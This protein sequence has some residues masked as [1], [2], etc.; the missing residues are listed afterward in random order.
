MTKP[1]ATGCIKTDD[2]VSWQTFNF[3]LESV[4]L[5]DKIGHLYVVDIE[6]NFEKF[7]ARQKVYNEICPPIIEKKKVIDIFERS[8]YQLTKHYELINNKVKSYTPTKKAHA[9]LFSKRCF[10]MYIEHLAIVIKRLGWRVTKIHQH[11]TFEQQRF[12]KDFIIRNQ[13]SRQNA[14]NNIEKDFYKL[15]NNSNFGYDCRNNLDNC[16]FTPIYDEL[17]EVS[18]LKKYYNYFDPAV[19]EFVSTDLIKKE[20]EETNLDRLN[21]IKADNKFFEVKKAAVEHEKACDLDALETFEA[22][23]KKS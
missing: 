13:V 11:I 22:K 16:T 20:I 17:Q 5:D 7:T 21:K 10:P 18:Y 23:K 3:L 9:T 2:D 19:K 8:N 1:M 15:L 14:K 4:S 6:L 12:K